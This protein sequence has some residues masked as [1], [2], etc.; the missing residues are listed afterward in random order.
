MPRSRWR[1]L[2][3]YAGINL[4]ECFA[5]VYDAPEADNRSFAAFAR[6]QQLGDAALKSPDSA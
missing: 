6:T 2:F 5:D 3:K 4:R 1:V